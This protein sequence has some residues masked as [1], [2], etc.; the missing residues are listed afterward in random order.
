LLRLLD[1]R[2]SPQRTG[3]EGVNGHEFEGESVN[4]PLGAFGGVVFGVGP[5]RDLLIGI[6]FVSS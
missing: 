6:L 3:R 2:S 4:D 5:N 1:G